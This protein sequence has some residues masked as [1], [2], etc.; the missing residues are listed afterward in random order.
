[1]IR[2]LSILAAA[3]AC[4]APLAAQRAVPAMRLLRVAD[5]SGGVVL[6]LDSATIA[7]SADSSFIVH[8]VH[9]FPAGGTQRVAADRKVESQEMD[10][11]RTRVR[12]HQTS[13]YLGDD[14]V[15]VSTSPE[16][17]VERLKGWQPVAEDELPLFRSICTYL[18]GSFAASLPMIVG[19]ENG[20]SGPELLNRT[21]VARA[22]SRA[23]PPALRAARIT[24]T[25][26]VRFRVTPEGR[27]DLGTI[28]VIRPALRGLGSAAL[29]VV[30]RMR[31]R[32]A[33]QHG[34][35]VS[36]WVSLP[37]TFE[38]QAEPGVGPPEGR[39]AFPPP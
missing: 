36:V 37:V 9:Q 39:P 16:E 6:S 4:A 26:L 24:G 12:W 33:R 38:P 1:M 5:A 29:E 19:P 34:V 8:V 17:P 27:V 22:L 31:F 13:M 18:L 25:V 7:R 28:R 21:E 2:S 20:V 32:P 14:L 10:C 15:P 35:P 11:A 3:L 30:S 23:Y